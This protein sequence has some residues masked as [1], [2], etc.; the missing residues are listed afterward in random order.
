M[1]EILSDTMRKRLPEYEIEL[2]VA[3][4]LGT[5]IFSS[6]ESEGGDGRR[7]HG[8]RLELGTWELVK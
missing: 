6:V 4:L 1:I 8:R 5:L 7:R 3:W 2:R